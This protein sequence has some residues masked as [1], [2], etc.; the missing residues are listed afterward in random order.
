MPAVLLGILPSILG[1]LT[2]NG[3]ITIFG[4]FF[5][6]AAGGDIF[7]LWLLR[8]VKAGVLVE[9]HPKRMGCYIIYQ[10]Y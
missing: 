1:I 7:I 9:D 6:L 8:K 5:I 3:Y 2:G 10:D 4:L